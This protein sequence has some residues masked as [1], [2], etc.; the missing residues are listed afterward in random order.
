LNQVGVDTE[1]GQFD[2]DQITTGVTSSQR[3]KIIV[4]RELIKTLENKVG[5]I[6]PVEELKKEAEIKGISAEEIDEAVEKLKRSGDIFEPK[7]KF[8]SRI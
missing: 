7:P 4:V 1:T 3:S 8:L 2:I 5:K 6:F